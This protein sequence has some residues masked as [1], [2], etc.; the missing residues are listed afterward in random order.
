MKYFCGLI[1]IVLLLAGM[2]TQTE[3]SQ[4]EWT[5]GMILVWMMLI[6]D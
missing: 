5:V 1:G 3:W 4:S 6:K 2:L